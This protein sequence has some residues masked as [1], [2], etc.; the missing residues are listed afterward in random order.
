MTTKDKKIIEDSEAKGIPI[1]VL[2]AKDSLAL[3]AILAYHKLCK[4]A[5]CSKEHTD[6][7]MRRASEFEDYEGNKKLPD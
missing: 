5:G 2:T 6:G 1:F 3:D 7:V 4:D